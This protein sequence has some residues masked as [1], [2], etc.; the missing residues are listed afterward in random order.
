MPRLDN[1]LLSARPSSRPTRPP[2]GC[3]IPTVEKMWRLLNTI[4]Q[5]SR[6]TPGLRPP[7][8]AVVSR[9]PASLFQTARTAHAVKSIDGPD[10][11]KAGGFLERPFPGKPCP[12]RLTRGIPEWFPSIFCSPGSRICAFRRGA[13]HRCTIRRSGPAGRH[14]LSEIFTKPPSPAAAVFP[15]TP[16][17]PA[18]ACIGTGLASGWASIVLSLFSGMGLTKKIFFTRRLR[19]CL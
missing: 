6:V 1:D 5:G 19:I 3:S 9:G 10:E 14:T 8:G 2:S 12:A 7:Y 16:R 11:P 17:D 15:L 18:C 4:L 13:A